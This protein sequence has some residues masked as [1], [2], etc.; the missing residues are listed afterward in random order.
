MSNPFGDDTDSNKV[1]DEKKKPGYMDTFF[2]QVEQV[3]Q[4][5]EEIQ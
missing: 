3:K 1:E 4:F 5:I 2:D